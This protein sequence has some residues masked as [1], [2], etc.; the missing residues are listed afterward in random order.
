[1]RYGPRITL[2]ISLLLFSFCHS[3]AQQTF[4]VEQA[5]ESLFSLPDEN[6]NYEEFYERYFLLYDKP[7][8]LNKA[9]YLDLKSLFVL[10][11]IEIK[12]ILN[13]RDSVRTVQSIYELA[14]LEGITRDKL[15]ALAPFISV[16]MNATVND[17]ITNISS[18]SNAYLI[19]RFERRI[20]TSQG[21]RSGRFAGDRNRIYLR[22][23]NRIANQ[24]SY[25][26][27]LEKDPGEDFIFDGSTYRYGMDYWSA[28][29]MIENQK[30]LK[31]IIIGDYQLQFGQG[32]VFG[33]GLS[34]GKGAEAINT[35]EKVSLGIR[36]YTSVI[37]GGYLRGAAA[38]YELTDHWQATSFFSSLRQDA[39]LR[40]LE[41]E[42]DDLVF[43]TFQNSGLHRT[44]AEIGNKKR[45][46]ELLSGF[47][48]GYSNLMGTQ[49][50]VLFNYSGFSSPIDR[51]TD[52]VN[53]HEFSGKANVNASLYANTHIRQFRLFGE[54]AVSKNGGIGGLA[55]ITGDLSPQLEIALLARIYEKD[56]HSL[57][58]G[59]FG[60][61]SRNINEEGVY[62]G[63]RYKL[64]SQ[65]NIQFYYDQYLFRWLRFRINKPSKG[66]DLMARVNCSIGRKARF[67][68]QFRKEKQDRNL[69]F[70]NDL[71]VAEGTSKRY[72]LHLDFAAHNHLSLRSKIQWNSYHIADSFSSGVAFF[73]DLSYRVKKH[74]FDL[75]F[76]LFDTNGSNNRQ[77]AYEQDLLYNFSIPGLSG[78]GIRNYLLWKYQF[79]RKLDLGLKLSRT[80]FYDRS[81]IGTGLDQINGNI[82]TDLKIQ[83]VYRF[84]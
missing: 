13:Y 64:N 46:R 42:N 44:E 7:L 22:Y 24:M 19:T 39:S 43:S 57:R 27:T 41:I 77:Y 15:M 18:Q 63:L 17:A 2:Q 10:T 61:G 12:Q 83:A 37:E 21:Y 28:H 74:R 82:V 31:R 36:P 29:V 5:I 79:S 66:Y 72:I 53:K 65:L 25:G 59:A 20:E 50:G 69:N 4:D 70:N 30:K 3:H 84:R 23:R 38:T 45:V 16:E 26:L 73:Q 40:T 9:Q 52:L 71:I 51:S 1:M 67:Y 54:L 35:L 68:F 47:N 81:Q 49:F 80:T 48:L 75:R 78:K 14:Y 34:I 62:V 56:F 55:G 33:S 6:I 11:E 60:E 32:L 58:S 8:D 76:S